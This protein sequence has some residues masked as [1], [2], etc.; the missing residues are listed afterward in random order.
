MVI[1]T[2]RSDFLGDLQLHPAA[3]TLAVET[4]QLGPMPRERFVKVIEGPAQLSGLTLEPGL[5]QGMIEDTETNDALPLLAFTLRE[6]YEKFGG[7]KLLKLAEYREGLGGLS[8]SVAKAAE[9]V[10]QAKP[11]S[12]A[13]QADLRHAFRTLVRVNEEGKYVRQPASRSELPASVRDV[14]ERFVQARLLVAGGEGDKQ[15]LE[16]A[17]EALFRSWER[18]RLWL[19]ED[20]EF[21]LWQQR[22]HRAAGEWERTSRDSDALLRGASLA[23]AERNFKNDPGALHALDREYIEKSVEQRQREQEESERART[24]RERVQKRNNRVLSGFLALAL[25]LTAVALLLWRSATHAK[26]EREV[27]LKTVLGDSATLRSVGAHA[28]TAS[29]E[30]GVYLPP[31]KTVPTTPYNYPGVRAL[32]DTLSKILDLNKLSVV[33]SVP[34]FV[35]ESPHRGSINYKSHVSFGLYNPAFVRWAGDNL[36]PAAGDGTLRA[37]TTPFYNSFLG[38]M[39]RD[40]YLTHA[41]LVDDDTCRKRLADGYKSAI[42]AYAAWHPEKERSDSTD[43]PITPLDYLDQHTGQY[44]NAVEAARKEEGRSKWSTGSSPFFA[45]VAVGFWLR[46][47]MDG[48]SEGFHRLLE[49]LLTVYDSTWLNSEAP[50]L[51]RVPIKCDEAPPA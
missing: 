48:T 23:E 2:L 39:A 22:L 9:S 17:H 31:W 37:L 24:E 29:W 44:H 26:Q 14:L 45:T 1:S 50:K 21:L 16:V 10:Y 38:E 15:I 19:D 13:Q 28:I 4:L 51:P 27:V 33:S 43:E 36:I 47:G 41:D 8:G 49:K 40:Y 30:A 18:L 32:Y 20:R 34:I 6:L 3:R 46:R 42:N 35:G 11:L 25:V 7:D 5:T 12:A